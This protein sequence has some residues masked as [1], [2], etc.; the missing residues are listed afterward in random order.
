MQ[1]NWINE[2]YSNQLH[3]ESPVSTVISYL[4]RSLNKRTVYQSKLLRSMPT[5]SSP[6]HCAIESGSKHLLL[7]CTL[8]PICLLPHFLNAKC[9]FTS[10]PCTRLWLYYNIV[11]IVA[12]WV[13]NADTDRWLP[14]YNI[15]SL[16]LCRSKL[17]HSNGAQPQGDRDLV[18]KKK[19]KSNITSFVVGRNKQ[20]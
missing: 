3:S 14:P 4:H 10:V 13:F 16:R 6:L 7:L 8:A 9:C 20:G 5:D 12:V 2:M 18:W 1:H 17:L 19:L 11:F 15:G